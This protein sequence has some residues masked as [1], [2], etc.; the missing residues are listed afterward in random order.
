VSPEVVDR[1]SE[2]R[3]EDTRLEEEDKGKK[4]SA[5]SPFTPMAARMKIMIAVM[6]IMRTIRGF[7]TS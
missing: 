1:E 6:K 5:A 4:S 2:D 7:T 3:W